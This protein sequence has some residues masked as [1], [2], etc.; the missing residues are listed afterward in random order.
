MS[1]HQ[2]QNLKHIERQI[3]SR[4]ASM[5]QEQRVA[6]PS[7]TGQERPRI[8][9]FG[10]RSV[11]REGAWPS[12]VGDLHTIDALVEAGGSPYLIPTTPIIVGVDPFDLLTN[13]DAFRCVFE[14]IWPVIRDVHGMV[15]TG[16]G[17]L[18]ARFFYRQIPHPYLQTP[19]SWRDIWE[20]FSVLINWALFKTTFGICRGLQVMNVAL[21][22][23]LFQD[24]AELRTRKDVLP[25]LQHRR[26]RAI[27]KNLVEHPVYVVPGSWLAQAVRSRGDY[28]GQRY[29][30]DAV[31][32]QHHNFVGVVH[33]GTSDSVIGTL[34]EDLVVIGY[35]PD[36]VIE[37]IA[38]RDARHKYWAVQFHPEYMRTQAWAS[39]L[40]SFVVE[41]SCA[42]TV[43]PAAFFE[44]MKED[45]FAW[46]W[47]RVSTLHERPAPD[48]EGIPTAT[49]ALVRL[50]T[51]SLSGQGPTTESLEDSAAA[52]ERLLTLDR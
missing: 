5:I 6:L 45:I 34:A 20:W 31:F 3:C 41:Q 25:L 18:D 42:D 47:L 51:H 7:S 39:S 33:P 2:Q 16:G 9:I 8:G 21:G 28:A 40:F 13:K 52:D 24:H 11:V 26:G 50:T 43:L 12:Y 30:L 4:S 37:A 15:F 46:L 49:K 32:S 35:A 23:T 44:S 17:D 22:G 10:A 29:Y 36:G 48:H 19:D 1:I 14:T 38:S 27:F